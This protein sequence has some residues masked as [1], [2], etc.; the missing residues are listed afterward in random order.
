MLENVK[1]DERGL[2]GDMKRPTV[3]FGIDVL[4]SLAILAWYLRGPWIDLYGFSI[5]RNRLGDL[6]TRPPIAIHY[7]HGLVFTGVLLF[8]ALFLL[9]SLLAL[10][11]RPR[12]LYHAFYGYAPELIAKYSSLLLSSIVSAYFYNSLWRFHGTR[13]YRVSVGLALTVATFVLVMLLADWLIARRSAQ[14]RRLARA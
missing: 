11:G 3:I 8:V 1:T 13:L 14:H 4:A 5:F 12:S 7:I 2:E 10:T 6:A 9:A